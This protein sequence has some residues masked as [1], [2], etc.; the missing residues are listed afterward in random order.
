MN[1]QRED[2]KN[3]H[4]LNLTNSSMF[5]DYNSEE[6][7][8]LL[9]S[10]VQMLEAEVHKLN[11]LLKLKE[12]KNANLF[13]LNGEKEILKK[14]KAQIKQEMDDMKKMYE[15]QIKDLLKKVETPTSNRKSSFKPSNYDSKQLIITLELENTIE[16]LMRENKFYSEQIDILKKDIENSKIIKENQIKKM[17]EDIDDANT[18][19]ATAKVSLAQAIFEKDSEIVKYKNLCRKLKLRLNNY[20]SNV[21]GGYDSNNTHATST[22]TAAATPKRRESFFEKFFKK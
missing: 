9:Q 14:E 13:R 20:K 1:N 11:S 16:K 5:N 3:Y 19:A 2:K 17:K 18:V 10:R 22:T 12:N 6:N 21:N 15:I 7:A 4:T 8:A